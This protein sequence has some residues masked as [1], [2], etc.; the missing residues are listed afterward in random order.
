MI[1]PTRRKLRIAEVAPLWTSVPPERYGGAE[2]MVSWL[3]EELVKRGHEVTLFAS[4]DSRTTAKLRPMCE[5][6]IIQAMARGEAYQYEPYAISALVES[7]KDAASF[8]VIHSHVGCAFVPIAELSRTPVLHTV[9]AALDLVDELWTLKRYPN[10][11]IAAI[12]RSQVA[13]ALQQGRE[14]VRVIYHGCDFDRFEPSFATGKYLAF[15]SRMNPQ[16]NPL[17]AIQVATK[18]GLPI[19]LAGK[20][21]TPAEEAYFNEQIKPLF[22]GRNIIYRGEVSQ[23]E[24]YDFLRNA[25][26]LLFPIQWEEHF[27]LVMIEAMA[28]GTPVVACRRGSVPEV[29]DPGKTGF[30]ANSVDELA[31]LVPGALRLNRRAVWEHARSRFNHFRMVDDYV[32]AF[33]ALVQGAPV[34]K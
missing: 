6:N 33:E 8:D 12:S 25:S 28:C 32:D 13:L 1:T 26:A 27:G 16:K 29:V 21:Q 5:R 24:K 10:A 20:P 3:T 30:Y 4:A 34:T 11:P 19:V 15:I 14:N 22:D 18:V 9:H 17:G 31:A 2:L 23:A 7:L